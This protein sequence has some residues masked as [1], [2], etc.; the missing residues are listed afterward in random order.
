M[1]KVGAFVCTGCDIGQAIDVG[2]LEEPCSDAGADAFVTHE[3]LCSPEGLAKIREAIADGTDG[4]VIGAC[5]PR[6]MTS[7]FAFDRSEV[8]IERV[9][10]REQVAWTHP[11]GDEDTQLLAADLMRMG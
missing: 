5:S 6:S 1:N 7:E 3:C 10:L 4:V 8:A 11:H 9:S 2:E